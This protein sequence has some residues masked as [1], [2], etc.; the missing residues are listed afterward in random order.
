MNPL[1]HISQWNLASS[2]AGTCILRKCKSKFDSRPNF[3]PQI[4]QMV[5]YREP[6]VIF[7]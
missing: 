6:M 3:A 2:T 1:L 4:L 7:S 5:T